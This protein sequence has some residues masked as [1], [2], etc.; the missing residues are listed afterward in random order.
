[1]SVCTVSRILRVYL[2]RALYSPLSPVK[3]GDK[4]T[5]I[6][7]PHT[8]V[9]S[10]G[11][12]REHLPQTLRRT[13]SSTH[14]SRGTNLLTVDRLCR[15]RVMLWK[16]WRV[17]W[18]WRMEAM[19][20]LNTSWLILFVTNVTRQRIYKCKRW[21]KNTNNMVTDEVAILG[22]FLH[23]DSPYSCMGMD[24]IICTFVY[25]PGADPLATASASS[26][27]IFSVRSLG[28]KSSTPLKA[29]LISDTRAQMASFEMLIPGM[30][31]P[32][33]W[34]A[35]KVENSEVKSAVCTCKKNSFSAQCGNDYIHIK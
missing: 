29:L 24:Y 14:A 17:F 26:V 19:M 9:Q 8:L 32:G 13:S 5:R 33:R 31:L 6:R 20:F 18:N 25:S 11:T 23:V 35:R 2:Q 28:L 4:H 15:K 21:T 34:L 22:V 30:P 10:G 12:L 1:M 27:T 3:N 7:A 16:D